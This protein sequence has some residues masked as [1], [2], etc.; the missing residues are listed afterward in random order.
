MA[1]P[2][3]WK[4][5]FGTKIVG[6]AL[7]RGNEILSLPAPARHCDVMRLAWDQGWEKIYPEEQGFIS[8]IGVFLT[9]RQASALALVSGMISVHKGDTLLSEDLW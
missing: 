6:V 8:D 1:I 3:S 9:R 7:K 5:R 4:R 2:K